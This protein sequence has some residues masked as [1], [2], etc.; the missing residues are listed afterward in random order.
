MSPFVCIFVCVYLFVGTCIYI[1]LYV[2]VGVRVCEIVCVR[3]FVCAC[4]FLCIC[5]CNHTYTPLFLYIIYVYAHTF[6]CV[7]MYL[8]RCVANMTRAAQ[9]VHPGSVSKNGSV[10]KKN[11]AQDA[12][13]KSHFS[14]KAL[15]RKCL[16][17][18]KS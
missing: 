12:F 17:Y 16:D 3:V 14:A 6:V 1:T 10:C 8:H 13:S 4:L 2:C 5:I 9:G 11:K 7:C 18:V 15:S